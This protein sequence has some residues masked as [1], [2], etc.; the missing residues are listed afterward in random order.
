M[1]YLAS[2]LQIVASPL[3]SYFRE[4]LND[5]YVLELPGDRV[6]RTGKHGPLST[7]LLANSL[8]LIHRPRVG[9]FLPRGQPRRATYSLRFVLKV[10]PPNLTI[11]RNP[12]DLALSLDKGLHSEKLLN[13]LA[14]H[15]AVRQIGKP[16]SN[17]STSQLC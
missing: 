1:T 11:H 16:F 15:R 8:T 10:Q 3:L 2:L 9:C 17:N 12:V 13:K 5:R 7:L 14:S 4:T 6:L